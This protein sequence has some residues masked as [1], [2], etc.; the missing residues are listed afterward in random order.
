M[1]RTAPYITWKNGYPEVVSVITCEVTGEMSDGAKIWTDISCGGQ[2]F[3][4]RAAGR[5]YFYK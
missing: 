5:F 1:R 4:G 2:F 3:L